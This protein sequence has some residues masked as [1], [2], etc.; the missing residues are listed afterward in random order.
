MFVIHV[1]IAVKLLAGRV[2]HF[3]RVQVVSDLTVLCGLLDGLVVGCVCVR[4]VRIVRLDRSIFFRLELF[5]VV[6]RKPSRYF[7][8][9]WSY[10]KN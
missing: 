4:T 8:N 2:F 10:K 3:D 6:V 9:V 5:L 7:E 1:L